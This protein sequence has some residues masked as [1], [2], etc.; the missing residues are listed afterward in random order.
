MHAKAAL[1]YLQYGHL[2]LDWSGFSRSKLKVALACKPQE[3]E[4]NPLL[5]NQSENNFLLLGQ[6]R[7]SLFHQQLP[8]RVFFFWLLLWTAVSCELVVWGR[9]WWLPWH[10]CQKEPSLSQT[11]TTKQH[12][13]KKWFNLC[14]EQERESRWLL[15]VLSSQTPQQPNM[16]G[17]NIRIHLVSQCLAW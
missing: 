8:L 3:L 4:P 9:V 7:S 5:E 13:Q 16:N 10:A 11:N 15:Y 14:V 6:V 12:T 17:H 1:H 2:E